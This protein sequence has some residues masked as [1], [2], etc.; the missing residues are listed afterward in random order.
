MRCNKEELLNGSNVWCRFCFWG[1]KCVCDKLCD[2]FTILEE[3]NRNDLI[4][5]LEEGLARTVNRRTVCK[6]LESLREELEVWN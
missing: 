1:N 5:V 6:V 2:D 3:E 4:E